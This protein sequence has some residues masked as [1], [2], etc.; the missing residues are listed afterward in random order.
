MGHPAHPDRRLDQRRNPAVI[1]EEQ[2][3][4]FTIGTFL[5]TFLLTTAFI[6]LLWQ[7]P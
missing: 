6:T 2:R 3:L 4:I 7:K 1:R 5:L